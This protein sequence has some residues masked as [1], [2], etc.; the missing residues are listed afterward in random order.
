MSSEMRSVL[1]PVRGLLAARAS[2]HTE[3][4]TLLG[5]L[6]GVSSG[7]LIDLVGRAGLTGRGGAAF[8]MARKL[9]A[10]HSG[11]SS[12]V[13][14]NGAEGEPASSKDLALIGAA[15]HLILDGLALAAR[16]TKAKS[17]Y[18]YAPG[19]V[20]DTV[21]APALRERGDKVPVT[22][23]ASADTFVSG[24]ETAVVAAVQGLRPLPMHVPPVYQG[25]VNGRPTLVQNVETLAHLALVA[26]YGADWFRDRGISSDPGTRLLTISGAVRRPAVHEVAG[27]TPLGEAINRAGGP[28]GSL[29]AVLIGGYHGAWVPWNAETIHLPLDRSAL[30]P[31]DAA[32]GAGV[33]VALDADRCGLD[34]AA[35]IARYLAGQSAGQCGPCRNGLPTIADH[36]TELAARRHPGEAAREIARICGSVQGRGACHHPDGTIGMVRSAM[37]TFGREIDLHLHGQCAGWTTNDVRSHR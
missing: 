3:H 19:H 12:V 4:L 37:R 6:P 35:G 23:V 33:L 16:A 18:F 27:G 15:P 13:V 10:V 1:T 31:Y 30:A 11:R 9:A 32:P 7:E 8:P 34:A 36:L 5:A 20:L 26:R 17:A 2:T 28:T 21:V 25:G 24:Q 22:L 14:A 29:Q